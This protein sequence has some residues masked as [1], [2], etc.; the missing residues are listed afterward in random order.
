MR[1]GSTALQVVVF[2]EEGAQFRHRPVYTEIVHRAHKAGLA[3]A[4]VLRGIEGFGS[5]A[6]IHTSRILSLSQNLPV[7]VVMIDDEQRIRDFL[8]QLEE[9]VEHGLITVT[10]VEVYHYVGRDN[11]AAGRS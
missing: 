3:G 5:S 2:V 10:A 9:V 4:S 7:T 8:P 1:A 6:H 11:G